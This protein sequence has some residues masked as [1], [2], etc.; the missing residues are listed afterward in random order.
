MSE[1]FMKAPCLHCPFKRDVTPFLN[2]DRAY[3]I[4][5]NA[6]N[7]YGSFPCHKTTESDDDS[8]HGEMMVVETSKECAGHLYM[9]AMSNGSCYY[10]S[11]GFKPDPKWNCYEDSY[12]MYEAYA[13]EWQKSHPDYEI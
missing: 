6:E 12:E 4:A 7:R 3:D 9:K 11:E 13:E 2:P 5:N 10:E 8:E 1:E